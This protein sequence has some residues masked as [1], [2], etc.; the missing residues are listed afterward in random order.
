MVF[1]LPLVVKGIK[2]AV[3]IGSVFPADGGKMAPGGVRH[4]NFLPDGEGD[5]LP[6]CDCVRF[7]LWYLR[8]YVGMVGKLQKVIWI[9]VPLQYPDGMTV[10]L[11][12][13][14]FLRLYMTN[15]CFHHDKRF[16]LFA[17]AIL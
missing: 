9:V 6:F 7:C 14:P 2:Y 11:F 10:I 1:L 17:L 16:R 5:A 12:H 15:K 8:Q 3:R 13:I 4:S